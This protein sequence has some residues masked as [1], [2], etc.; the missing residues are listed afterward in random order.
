MFTY[1]FIHPF[2]YTILIIYLFLMSAGKSKVKALNTFLHLNWKLLSTSTSLH[3]LGFSGGREGGYDGVRPLGLQSHHTAH[4]AASL[5]LHRPGCTG[6]ASWHRHGIRLP[7]VAEEQ[8]FGVFWVGVLPVCFK[9]RIANL[10]V[11]VAVSAMKFTKRF[12]DF[13]PRKSCLPKARSVFSCITR[14][15]IFLGH[16]RQRSAEYDQV[17]VTPLHPG[18]EVTANQLTEENEDFAA[19][20]RYHQSTPGQALPDLTEQQ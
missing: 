13:V 15:T 16:C 8:V 9:D 18:V 6:G 20:S 1:I 4:H 17:V 7:E 10:E 2:T 19:R 12:S 11:S 5:R 3:R 14:L